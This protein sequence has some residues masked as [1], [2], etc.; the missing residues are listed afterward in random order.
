MALIWTEWGDVRSL[1]LL[2]EQSEARPEMGVHVE[3][4]VDMPGDGLILA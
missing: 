4:P 2:V 3:G 1:H